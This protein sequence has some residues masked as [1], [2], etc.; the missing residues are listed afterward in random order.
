MTDKKPSLD[1]IIERLKQNTA[2]TQDVKKQVTKGFEGING[3]LTSAEK[4]LDR[5][6]WQRENDRAEIEHAKEE[7]KEMIADAANKAK[8][9]VSDKPGIGSTKWMLATLVTI[10]LAL[11]AAMKLN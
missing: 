9:S 1:V 7:A 5:I 11:I 8:D 4:R 6:E 2:L 10:I 3:R